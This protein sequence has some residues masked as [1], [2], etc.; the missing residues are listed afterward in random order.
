MLGK[1]ARA[2]AR[3][4]KPDPTLIFRRKLAMEMMTKQ[5]KG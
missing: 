4:D 5:N 3:D 1:Q 2:R